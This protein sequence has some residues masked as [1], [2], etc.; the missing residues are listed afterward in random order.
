MHNEQLEPLINIYNKKLMQLGA[1]IEKELQLC[2]RKPNSVTLIG[3][4]KKQNIQNIQ[5]AI[6][7]GLTDIGENY[8]QEAKTKFPSLPPVCKHFIGHIQTNKAK[9]IVALFDVVQS[10][11]RIEAVLALD[12]AAQL[13]NKILPVLLQ[14]NISPTERFGCMPIDA[15]RL[16]EQIHA[17]NHLQL[18][19]IMAIGPITDHPEQQA[20]AFA[21]AATTLREIGGS[22]LSL[23]M[24]G[25]WRMAVRAGSTMLRMGTALFGKR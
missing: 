1:E 12:K 16:A 9:Q 18:Q 2:G 15:L 10:V 17:A 21:Q 23:G 6:L 14:L 25:D 5:A 8:L 24:S 4:S 13:A 20:E 19:G 22:V 7:A 11:D 3:V